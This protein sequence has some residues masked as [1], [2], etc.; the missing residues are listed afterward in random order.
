V[1][2]A[3]SG[4]QDLPGVIAR[5]FAVERKSLAAICALV[6][7]GGLIG[8]ALSKREARAWDYLLGGI[9]VGAV[10]VAGWYLTGVVGHVIEHPQTL[11][12]AWI[13]TNTAKMESL[14]FV[15]PQAF[16]LELLLLW[17]DQS[18]IVTFGI[19]STIGVVVGSAV[20]AVGSGGF[21]WESF[22][23]SEDLL[24]HV[25]AGVLMGFGGVLAL[26]C[27]VGQGITG[28][29]TLA[30]GSFITFAAIVAGALIALKYQTW[31]F[32]QQL[33]SQSAI[34]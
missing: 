21:R 14:T 29:S 20:Y 8:F 15:G 25:L 4:P 11:Q 2:I 28:L 12:E 31:R 13:A 27:T 19:A 6:V 16:S 7:G 24:N 17:T 5:A 9:T 30:L 32:E 1:A 23:D 3:L 26:G 34:A 10:I 18:R 22:R 33:T